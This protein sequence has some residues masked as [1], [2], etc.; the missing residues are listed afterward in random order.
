MTV[1]TKLILGA[2]GV[3]SSAIA[4]HFIKKAVVKNIT[5]KV[6]TLDDQSKEP[7]LDSEH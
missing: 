1:K 2:V 6:E 7:C 5:A 3:L 4:F